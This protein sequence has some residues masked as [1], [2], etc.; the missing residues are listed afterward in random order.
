MSP[1]AVSSYD[2]ISY[3]TW[4]H[5]IFKDIS[6]N[7]MNIECYKTLSRQWGQTRDGE[8]LKKYS[9]KPNKY[10][11]VNKDVPQI[12]GRQTHQQSRQFASSRSSG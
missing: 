10:V 6:Y 5:D 11:S 7:L 2:K 9:Q 3:N 12:V 8:L 4:L 1:W